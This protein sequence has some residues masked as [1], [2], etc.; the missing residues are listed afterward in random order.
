M[1]REVQEP[2]HLRLSCKACPLVCP[3]L[4]DRLPQRDRVEG[5]SRVTGS[6]VAQAQGVMYPWR[7]VLPLPF[8]AQVLLQRGCRLTCQPAQSPRGPTGQLLPLHRKLAAPGLSPSRWM[9]HQRGC[10][11]CL[12]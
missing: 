1:L 11:C 6:P 2:S 8:L 12:L 9:K 5:I 7:Q 10:S 4:L 3:N